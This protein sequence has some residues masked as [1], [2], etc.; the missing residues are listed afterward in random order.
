MLWNRGHLLTMSIAVQDED[1][2]REKVHERGHN[3]DKHDDRDN[4]DGGHDQY[5]GYNDEV[6]SRYGDEEQ[7]GPYMT[8]A[9]GV[10]PVSDPYAA[11]PQSY[12]NTHNYSPMP[13]NG[14]YHPQGYDRHDERQL[15][16]SADD[17][18]GYN[19]E[20]KP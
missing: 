6:D 5:N 19:A 1:L 20:S 10:Y 15:P 3:R 18:S 11:H 4:F 12:T 17:V 13:P 2:A 16:P 14:G 7:G 9:T 8:P